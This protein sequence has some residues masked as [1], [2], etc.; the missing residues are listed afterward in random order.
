[1]EAAVDHDR[2]GPA[3]RIAADRQRAA[4]RIAE[5]PLEPARNPFA[6]GARDLVDPQAAGRAG[7][8]RSR[9]AT[10][11]R[12][13]ARAAR[14]ARRR[15]PRPPRRAPPARDRRRPASPAARP[16]PAAGGRTPSGPRG[17]GCRASADPS[18]AAARDPRPAASGK[19]R[20]AGTDTGRRRTSEAPTASS[21]A[22]RAGVAAR[23]G[24][25]RSVAAV[26]PSQC[27]Q[28][29]LAAHEPLAHRALQAVVQLQDVLR[30]AARAVVGL[31]DQRAQRRQ[32]VLE[33]VDRLVGCRPAPATPASPARSAPPPAAAR[34]RSAPA[35][36][37]RARPP[38][39]TT[40][41]RAGGLRRSPRSET[42]CTTAIPRRRPPAAAAASRAR[43]AR[44]AWPGQTRRRQLL[45]RLVEQQRILARLLRKHPLGQ[46]RDEDDLE[47]AAAQLRRTGDQHAAVAPRRRVG[48]RCWPADRPARARLRPAS[49]DRSRPSAADR[50]AR[51]APDRGGA[52]R[53]A[54]APR[55]DPAIPPTSPAPATPPSA[56]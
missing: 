36:S 45:A 18:A 9:R 23:I 24:R 41:A 42:R 14:T 33:R 4:V 22:R 6:A 7:S 56:A 55:S 52:A 15:S 20:R 2:L 29:L 26:M 21:G 19:S 27:D 44:P 38:A 48:S 32:V 28:R 1:M 17:R 10:R 11:D 39:R 5:R 13:P 34:R 31:V 47:R 46:R 54:R 50:R 8:R 49:P 30:A 43:L 3:G 35:R 53:G 12:S 16:R 25:T 51:A 37:S 40:T